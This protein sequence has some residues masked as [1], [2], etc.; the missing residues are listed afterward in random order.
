[1]TDCKKVIKNQS[2][3]AQS[4]HIC[5]QPYLFQTQDSF[6]SFE[7][8]VCSS[9][10]SLNVQ[11][12][13][14]FEKRMGMASCDCYV[15]WHG[16]IKEDDLQV[17]KMTQLFSDDTSTT[18]ERNATVAY[19]I[20]DVLLNFSEELK[21][22]RIDDHQMFEGLLPVSTSDTG[23][24]HIFDNCSDNI[25]GWEPRWAITLPNNL[26][27]TARKVEKYETGRTLR[28]D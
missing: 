23:H 16:S 10:K 17:V 28:R 26:P 8:M 18:P 22:Y 25:Y 3:T 20:C 21:R 7:N 6:H 5:M 1:M 12:V 19:P 9:M 2:K 27:T 13:Y 11:D 4:D 24:N 14:S 15:V